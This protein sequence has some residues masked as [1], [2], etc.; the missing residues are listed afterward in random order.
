MSRDKGIHWD[1]YDN[2]KIKYPATYTKLAGDI[3]IDVNRRISRGDDYILAQD[4]AGRL[5]TNDYQFEKK[6]PDN[7]LHSL[8]GMELYKLMESVSGWIFEKTELSGKD[9]NQT[10]YFKVKKKTNGGDRNA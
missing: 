8:A 5:N 2:F 6:I 3:Q 7:I 1:F 4:L 10:I 9:Y